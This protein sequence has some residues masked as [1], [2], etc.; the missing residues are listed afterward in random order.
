MARHIQTAS[1]QLDT[2]VQ[3]LGPAEL[4][5][6]RGGGGTPIASVTDLI[7]DPFHPGRV[8]SEADLKVRSA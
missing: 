6:V 3:T 8:F 5:Q 1:R 2:P 4:E 7:I